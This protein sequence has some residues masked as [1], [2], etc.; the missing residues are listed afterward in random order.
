[1][2]KLSP[3]ACMAVITLLKLYILQLLD[4]MK[5]RIAE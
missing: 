1:M 2:K 4:Q 5:N 3:A